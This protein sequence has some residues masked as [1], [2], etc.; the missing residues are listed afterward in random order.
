MNP[1]PARD[2]GLATVRKAT[3]WVAGAAVVAVGAFAA[4]FG[5][6]ADASAKT[7]DPVPSGSRRPPPPRPRPRGRRIAAHRRPSPRPPRPPRHPPTPF[8]AL[9][10]VVNDDI[11]SQRFRALGT[12]VT[13]LVDRAGDAEAATA[14]AATELPR[15]R[16]GLQP[17]PGRLRAQSPVRPLR[18]RDRGVASPR[19][20]PAHRPGRRRRHRR[21]GRPD[22]RHLAAGLGLRPGLLRGPRRAPPADRRAP[23][24]VPG[25]RTVRFDHESRTVTVPA[26][27]E[28]D[29]GA[30]GKGLAADRAA[31]RGERRDRAPVPRVRRRR[32]RRGRTGAG[33]AAGTCSS[34]TITRPVPRP[35]GR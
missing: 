2:Q 24:A 27:V 32:H 17:L 10:R 1:R 21:P 18:G 25:W 28:L 31:G 22:H 35:R 19:R 9:R 3:I 23:K 26:D 13:V 34:P 11:V 16:R 30:T 12:S 8:G 20:R 15:R 7:A 6:P 33:G 5:R 29:L 14:A 4:L